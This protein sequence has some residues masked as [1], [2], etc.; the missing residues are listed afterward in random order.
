MSSFFNLPER[1]LEA[2]HVVVAKVNKQVLLPRYLF[3]HLFT[4]VVV[5]PKIGSFSQGSHFLPHNPRKTKI[6]EYQT[7]SASAVHYVVGY[8]VHVNNA[9]VM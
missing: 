8:D 5:S 3:L 4:T 6:D 2:V 7:L 1:H 9:E